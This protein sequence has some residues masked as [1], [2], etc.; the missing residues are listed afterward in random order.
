M[1]KTQKKLRLKG[2]NTV[3]V[4]ECTGPHGASSHLMAAPSLKT[5]AT[6]KVTI[7]VYIFK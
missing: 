1:R 5:E 6:K 2:C 7:E 3:Q 4:L